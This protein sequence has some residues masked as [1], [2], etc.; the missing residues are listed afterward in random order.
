MIKNSELDIIL[1]HFLV[2]LCT[3][4]CVCVR[5]YVCRRE[6]LFQCN[7]YFFP[8]V[9]MFLLLPH[10][11]PLSAIYQGSPNNIK[12]FVGKKKI[13]TFGALYRQ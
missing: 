5:V 11:V 6:Y 2:P 8:N 10:V 9:A 1:R 4:V 12:L 7:H 3:N 13:I